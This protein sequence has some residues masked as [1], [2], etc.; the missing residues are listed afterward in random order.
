MSLIA[1]ESAT[2][3]EVTGLHRMTQ[4][5]L[6][7]LCKKDKLYQTPRLNDVLYLH[8]QG[9]ICIVQLILLIIL[10]WFLY[11]NRLSVYRMFGRIYRTQVFVARM[12]CYIRD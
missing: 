9:K 6:R 3:K 12:Q 1:G 5:G 11:F 4:K 7:D 2:R 10:F 8:Y